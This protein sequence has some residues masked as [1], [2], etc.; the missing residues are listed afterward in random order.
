ML[1]Q[2]TAAALATE[3]KVLSHPAAVDS[4]PTSGGKEDHNS[5]GATSAWKAL[6]IAENAISQVALELACVRWA[7]ALAGQEGLSPATRPVYERLA[8]LVPPPGRDR[9]LGGA[10]AKVRAAVRSGELIASGL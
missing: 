5:M 1:C 9:F 3:N 8:A 7:V 2:Y 10:I 6:R 4:I